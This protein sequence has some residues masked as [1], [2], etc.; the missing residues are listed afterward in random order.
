MRSTTRLTLALSL[1]CLSGCNAVETVQDAVAS[2][3]SDIGKLQTES[4]D[5]RVALKESAESLKKAGQTTLA[6]EVQNVADRAV[7]TSGQELRCNAEFFASRTQKVLGNAIRVLNGGSKDIVISP[8]TVCHWSPDSVDMSLSEDRRN[9]LEIS[10]YDLGNRT[11]SGDGLKLSLVLA[12][13]SKTDGSQFMS[14]VTFQQIV[15]NTAANGLQFPPNSSQLVLSWG[16]DVLSKV[17]ILMPHHGWDRNNSSGELYKKDFSQ[18]SED[19]HGKRGGIQKS[20]VF[21]L[22][23]PDARIYKVEFHHYGS[24]A[25]WNYN[26]NGGYAGWTEILPDGKSFVWRRL[27]G[28]LP[29]LEVYTAYYEVW[30]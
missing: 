26:P 7:A 1:V 14:S 29:T 3:N 25:G 4:I 15:V 9:K 11:G 10:G 18:T 5:W 20:G 2:I 24:Y 19:T 8:P 28:G 17:P 13:G 12:D 30:H 6:T 16:T 27:W 22:D 23:V 21:T